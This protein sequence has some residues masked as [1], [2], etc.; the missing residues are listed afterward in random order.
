VS[1]QSGTGGAALNR[2]KN[3]ESVK[4]ITD[5]YPHWFSEAYAKKDWDSEDVSVDQ[6]ALLALVAPRP[7]FL[8][9]AR[10]DVW[11]DPNGS[12]RSAQGASDT[13]KLYNKTGLKQ[14]SLKPFHPDADIG[15][16]LRSGTHGVVKEDWPA[17]LV[18]LDAHIK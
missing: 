10:R 14:D 17:F 11:S 4:E 5:T 15:F 2:K 13:Y 1:H 3:G 9:N 8:G 18:F 12:F 16:Y 7:I 6:H